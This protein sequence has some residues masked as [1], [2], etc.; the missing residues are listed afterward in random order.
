M[1]SE[2]P[3]VSSESLPSSK[4]FSNDKALLFLSLRNFCFSLRAEMFY[5]S[6]VR[7]SDLQLSIRELLKAD[8][9]NP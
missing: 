2:L 9:E 4:R 3:D 1:D 8:E 7:I 6:K 5:L